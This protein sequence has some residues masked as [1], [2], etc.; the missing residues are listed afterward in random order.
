MKKIFLISILLII[1]LSVGGCGV[2][3]EN[4]INE[5]VELE[6]V[7]DEYTY[8]ISKKLHEDLPEYRF[9]ASGNVSEL[10][11][12]ED[13]WSLAFVSALN[14]YDEDGLNILSVDFT[15]SLLEMAGN[16]IY[17]Q[18]LDTMGLHVVDVNFDGYKDVIILNS[19]YGAHSN[20]WY[21]CWLW[22]KETKSLIYSKSFAE[23]CNPAIDWDKQCIYSSGGTGAD[24]HDYAIYQYIDNQFVISNKLH[25]NG[26]NHVEQFEDDEVLAA[27]GVY[28]KEEELVN[29][30]METVHDGFLQK[31]EADVLI[32]NYIK[33]EP[34]ILESPRWYMFGGHHADVWLE[35]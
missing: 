9:I 17:Y 3:L 26:A 27:S 16:T 20:S 32:E 1:L 29:G 11:V 31:E 18:M 25:W 13:D 34:W 4:S 35:H 8:E 6:P 21:D 19:F 15:D 22:D 14:V 23:I 2:Q 12:S 28:V 33:E 30:L 5:K 10:T 24:N 7:T